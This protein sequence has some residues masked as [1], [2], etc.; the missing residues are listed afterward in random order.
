MTTREPGASDVF[1]HGLRCRPRSTAFRARSP[2]ASITA[3]FEVLVQLVIAAMT[4]DPCSSTSAGAGC[5]DEG[6]SV[7]PSPHTP[8]AAGPRASSPMAASL[9]LPDGVGGRSDGNAA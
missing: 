7:L 5:R 9:V 6:E 4:T 2:A 1:T 8:T 3:G